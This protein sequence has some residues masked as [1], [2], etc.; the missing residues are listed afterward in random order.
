MKTGEE[1]TGAVMGNRTRSESRPTD[2]PSDTLFMAPHLPTCLTKPHASFN[3][4]SLS[5]T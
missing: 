4:R 1:G 3:V 5:D 2:P